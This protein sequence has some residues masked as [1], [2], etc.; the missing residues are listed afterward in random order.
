V[1][2]TR[3]CPIDATPLTDNRYVCRSCTARL[4]GL[5]TDLPGLM[6]DLDV[7][8]AKQA[9]FGASVGGRATANS[10]AFGYAASEAGYV[11]R[12]TVLVWVDWIT[13]VR[14]HRV[15]E[16]WAEVGDYLANRAPNWIAQHPDGPQIVDELTAAIRHARQAIDRPA[17]RHYVGPCDALIETLNLT[18]YGDLH[19]VLIPVTCTQELYA[20]GDRPTVDCPRCGTRHDVR[21][22]QDA[23]LEQLRDHVLNAADMARAVDGL[24]V[25]LNADRIRQWKR[26]GL[27]TVALDNTDRPRADEKGRPL[28]RV[29]DV[30]DIV[31]GR[32]LSGVGAKVGA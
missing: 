12:Q 5:L 16:T 9:T 4:R 26:R 17:E 14:A 1:T 3:P 22:R 6:T 24:G 25:D 13:A 29:G 23:M 11:A 18:T 2:D 20:T 8:L 30:L 10:L 32:V 19:P 7:A 28:Y 27:L 15:P 21:A 31:A